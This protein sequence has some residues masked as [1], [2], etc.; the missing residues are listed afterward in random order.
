MAQ[1]CADSADRKQRQSHSHHR[2]VTRAS[3]VWIGWWQPAGIPLPQ[4]L[5]ELTLETQ[6]KISRTSPPFIEVERFQLERRET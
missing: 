5:T 6:S 3:A 2:S 4:S 1:G